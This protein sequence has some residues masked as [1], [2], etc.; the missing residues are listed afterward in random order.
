VWVKASLGGPPRGSELLAVDGEPAQARLARLA[1]QLPSA[2]AGSLA[3]A[4]AWAF[5]GEGE[6]PAVRLRFR[7]P[8]GSVGNQEVA[9]RPPSQALAALGRPKPVEELRPGIW[10]VDLDRVEAADLAG[11]MPRLAGAKGVVFDLR[12]YPNVAPDTFLSHLSDKPL[13]SARWNVPV[14]LE[15]DRQGWTWDSRGRWN[16][17]PRKPRIRGR[18]V[19][20]VGG[21]AISY[22]E[23]CLGIVE[24][25][26]LADLVGEPT[27]GTNG[28]VN[29]FRLPGGY[30]VS[31]TG[32]QVLKHDGTPHHGV[33]IHPTVPISP[34]PRGLA[35]GRD[36]V[37]AKGLDVAEA[38]R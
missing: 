38:G 35:A 14:I 30:Q 1:S 22:A 6:G 33:G 23:S 5:L 10:Y 27:A 31:W 36:E 32:M 19:F 21:G 18:V 11:A 4:Q 2:T 34:T 24:A 15:P 13:T 7:A 28:N 12:G 9:R 26:R 17:R 29:P 25:Y 3:H 16:L 8:D 20:L 37:L